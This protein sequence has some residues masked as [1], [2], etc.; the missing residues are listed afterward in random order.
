MVSGEQ[1]LLEL[2]AVRGRCSA[3]KLGIEK[4]DGKVRQGVS[5]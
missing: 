4:R 2:G 1:Y 5:S 3:L